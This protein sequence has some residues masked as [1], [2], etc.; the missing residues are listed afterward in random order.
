MLFGVEP[1]EPKND[2]Q[3]TFR[4]PSSDKRELKDAAKRRKRS[5]HNW[6]AREIV[7]RWLAQE[8]KRRAKKATR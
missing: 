6:L 3:I 7:L 2:D 8:R 1:S 5:G 4:I